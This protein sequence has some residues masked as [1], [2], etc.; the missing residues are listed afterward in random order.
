MDLRKNLNVLPS[1]GVV[2]TPTASGPASMPDGL[3]GVQ[4]R[5][6]QKFNRGLE[7]RICN[8]PHLCSTCGQQGHGA[9]LCTSRSLR[10]TS[11]NSAGLPRPPPG[12]LDVKTRSGHHANRPPPLDLSTNHP[13]HTAQAHIPRVVQ[14]RE[15]RSNIWKRWE[16]TSPRYLMYRRKAR[17]KKSGTKEDVWPD[18]VEEAFQIGKLLVSP[19]RG[20]YAN[21]ESHSD[22]TLCQ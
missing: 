22:P 8:L 2:L 3:N 17:A 16:L 21:H 13:Y 1:N 4:P 10:V 18:H 7:C 5:V 12:D 14:R 19:P 20:I 6:C 11:G 9:H 15:R